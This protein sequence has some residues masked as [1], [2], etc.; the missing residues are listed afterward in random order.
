MIP[1]LSVI[2]LAYEQAKRVGHYVPVDEPVRK[3]SPD[4][5]RAEDGRFGEGSGSGER[6]S[7]AL[8]YWTGGHGRE[9]SGAVR[10]AAAGRSTDP[11]TN[12]HAMALAAAIVHG[13]QAPALYRGMNVTDSDAVARMAG[14]KAGDHLDLNISSWSSSE[15]HASTFM[16]FGTGDCF[17]LAMEG[18][19][20]YHMG[21]WEHEWLTDG[22]FVVT[23][24]ESHTAEYG[25]GLPEGTPVTTISIRQEAVFDAPKDLFGTKRAGI[26]P[27]A[28]AQFEDWL[29]PY[30]DQRMAAP[31]IQKYSEDQPRDDHGRFGE[32]GG[33]L[34]DAMDRYTERHPDL[35]NPPVA[36]PGLNAEQ[37]ALINFEIH[38]INL[39]LA[40]VE[41]LNISGNEIH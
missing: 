4:Q 14:M 5:P 25:S 9:N 37:Q 17:L 15:D 16:R 24:T 27:W 1:V 7:A 34:A 29:E 18:A 36:I 10:E 32:G 26:V 12:A 28:S 20:G 38:K 30:M 8:D 3:Y 11:E 13:E 21:G 35:P 33:S 6:L 41:Y 22:R 23:G 40:K 39:A 19:T 31:D 2:E